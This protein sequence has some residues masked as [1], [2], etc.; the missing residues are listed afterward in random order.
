MT[1]EFIINFISINNDIMKNFLLKSLGVMTIFAM[2]FS[3]NVALATQ[4]N[5]LAICHATASENNPFNVIYVNPNGFNGHGDHEDDIIPITDLNN[6]QVVNDDDCELYEGDDGDE[7]TGESCEEQIF[8]SEEGE[9]MTEVSPLHGAWTASIDDAVWVWSENPISDA[10][11]ETTETFTLTFDIVGT[12]VDAELE[13]AADNEYVVTVNG[14]YVISDTNEDNYSSTGQDSHTIPAAELV[15]GENTIEFEVTNWA[16]ENG[17]PESNPAGLMYKLTV[18]CEDE[19]EDDGDTCDTEEGVQLNGCEDGDEEEG[20]CV[21]GNLITNGGFEMPDVTNGSG[22]QLFSDGTPDLDWNVSWIAPDG[23]AP[24]T[25]NLELHG[26]VNGWLAHEGSQYAELDTDYGSPAGGAASVEI[27]QEIDTVAGVTYELSYAFSARP[28]TGAGENELEVLVNGVPVQTQG[29]IAGAGANVWNTYTYSFEAEDDSTTISFRDAGTPNSV[30]TFLDD[31]SVNC[32]DEPE[33]DETGNVTICKLDDQENY[34]PGWDVSLYSTESVEQVQVNPDGLVDSSAVYGAGAY[35][36]EANGTYIYRNFHG[37]GTLFLPADAAY[38]LRHASDNLNPANYHEDTLWYRSETTGSLGIRVN[39]NGPVWGSAFNPSHQYFSEI[40]LPASDSF[41]FQILDNAYSDNTGFLTVDIY[42]GYT[43][44]TEED[45]CVTFEDVP[46]GTYDLSEIMQEGWSYVSGQGEVVVDEQTEEFIIVNHNDN[47]E[48]NPDPTCE[49]MQNCPE[50]ECTIDCEPTTP[51]EPNDFGDDEGGSSSGSRSGGSSNRGGEVLGAQT[52]AFCD[53]AIDTYMRRGY[54]NNPE[55]VKI[56]QWLLNKYVTPMP[57][58]P[59]DGF[60]GAG[61]E[62]AVKAFQI[63]YKDTI[64]TPWNLVTPTGIFF[65]TTLAT[66]KN[67][68]CPEEIVPVPTN[69]IPWSASVGV[70]P[71]KAQ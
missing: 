55:Q 20:V 38:S 52:E 53:F 58:L 7:T 19:P 11:N 26:G 61:T 29:P 44:T 56:L 70:V 8:V 45:G 28:S 15:S 39:G 46:F 31:V 68:E 36:L 30:G 5:S 60:Y 43:G 23:N 27:S 2:A 64:L 13:I 41:D 24:E 47:E 48:E 34:L 69:L 10:V 33:E 54:K 9:G 3:S 51:D 50:E 22:W 59:I 25:A 21:P 71:P 6:D 63:K 18:G 65:R 17:T 62:A 35:K 12:P 32:A 16:Q 37:L 4:D 42:P 67:L 14:D 1:G 40:N 49:E 66:A 57:P